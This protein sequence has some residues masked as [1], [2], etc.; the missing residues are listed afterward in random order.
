MTSIS[1]FCGLSLI[2]TNPSLRVSACTI[3]GEQRSENDI[4]TISGHRSNS[5]LGI[6]KLK[7][8]SKKEEMALDLCKAMGVADESQIQEY[9]QCPSTECQN[10][11]NA[12]ESFAIMTGDTESS[13]VASAGYVFNNCNVTINNFRK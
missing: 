8:D 11:I 5:G 10:M 13:S 2:Y 7:E 6:Y 12:N 4:K 3:L 1:G 9:N